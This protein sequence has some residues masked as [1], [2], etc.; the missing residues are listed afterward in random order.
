M[1][2][3]NDSGRAM[4]AMFGLFVVCAGV[5]VAETEPPGDW[6][7]QSEYAGKFDWIQTKS[8]E[9]VKG[10]II[11]M[12]DGDLE[13]DSDE[14]GDLTLGWHKIEQIRTSQV[15]NVRLLRNRSAVGKLILVG[16]E[17]TVY[18][19]QVEQFD[20][21]D[22]LTITAGTPKEINFWDMDVFVGMSI[23][24][25]NSDVREATLLADFKRRTILNRILLDFAGSWNVTD[26]VDVADSQ[27][28]GLKWD[29]FINDR[30]F[31][32]PIFGEYFRDP[33]QNIRGRYTVGF[34]L[35]YQL[36]D[37]SKVDWSLSGG[38]GYQETRFESVPTDEDATESTPVLAV[39]TRAEWEIFNWLDLD[40]NYR[41][42]LV[43]EASGSYNHHMVV[44]F[45]FSVTRILDFDVSWIWDRIE[46]PRADAAGITPR[47]DDFRTAVGLSFEF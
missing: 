2:V 29:K 46:N 22:V 38:P 12:Y 42:Q 45:E 23:L 24:S 26:D 31:V 41:L 3:L 16:D 43:N 4:L 40:G 33:F 28:V 37:S 19:Q 25:G 30:F 11:A 8:G 1:N 5:A 36:I 10:R 14:F 27:R 6:Q 39:G 18:G 21:R 17:V 32:S 13:F 20:K 47:P 35:G 15:V 7:P 44:S 34:G 9:W